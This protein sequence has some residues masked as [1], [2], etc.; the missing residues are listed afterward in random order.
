MKL[1]TIGPCLIALAAPAMATEPRPNVLF[2]HADDW[3]WGD[4]AC[5]GHPSITT[6][7]LDRLAKQGTDYHRVTVC[8]PVCSPSRTAIVAGQFPARQ[9]IHQHFAGHQE[10]V[11]RG[12][13]GWL[14]PQAAMLPGLFKQAGYATGHFGNWHLSVGGLED[15]PLPAARGC[16]EAVVWTGLGRDV[17]ESSTVADKIGTAHAAASYLTAAN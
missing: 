6:P 9:E 15:A 5:H 1:A 3:G 12:M 13:P 7:N 14:N 17:F 10:N 11:A 16:D 8:N 2:I 4:L